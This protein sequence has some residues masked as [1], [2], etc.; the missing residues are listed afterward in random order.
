[1]KNPVKTSVF[2]QCWGENGSKEGKI[3]DSHATANLTMTLD[4]L[5]KTGRGGL[6]K[7]EKI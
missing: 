7:K 3:E 6:K 4:F 5:K 2:L 1:L